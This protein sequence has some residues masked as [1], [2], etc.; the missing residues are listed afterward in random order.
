MTYHALNCKKHSDFFTQ[1]KKNPLKN[2][3]LTYFICY[4]FIT[5]STQLQARLLFIITPAIFIKCGAVSAAFSVAQT[6]FRV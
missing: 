1:K 6:L 5:K 3:V 2:I 4:I